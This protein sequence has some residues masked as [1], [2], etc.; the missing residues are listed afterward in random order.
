MPKKDEPARI[1]KSAKLSLKYLNKSKGSALD[2]FRDE[3]RRV[4]RQYIEFFWDIDKIPKNIPKSLYSLVTDSWLTSRALQCAAG[5]AGDIVRGTRTK[6]RQRAYRYGILLKEG[7][8]KAARKLKV[9]IDAAKVSKPDVKNVEPRLT[10]N[11]FSIDWDNPTSW[12]GI[13][14]LTSL[15]NKL[16]IVIPVKRH[17]H[18]N[19]LLDEAD[20]MCN[21]V[22]FSKSNVTLSF[23]M[24]VVPPTV[25]GTT[26]GLDIGM[27]NAFTTSDAQQST[28][29]IHGHTLNTIA[30]KLARK[31]KGS[32]AFARAQA[33]RTNYT[34]WAFNKIN[35]KGVS[36]LRVEN[37]KYLRR[38]KSTSRHLT[39]F[40]YPK[41]YAKLQ[42]LCN[43]YGCSMERV[44]PAYT[45]QRCSK[46]GRVRSSNRQG[47]LYKC[48]ACK[49]ECDSDYNAA[50][51]IAADLPP[52][53]KA[54]RLKRKNR[55]GFYCNAPMGTPI[56]SLTPNH[57]I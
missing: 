29:D 48:D 32:R 22:A 10:K 30:A 35:L 40:A 28:P 31:T 52:I 44:N 25:G 56:V 23:E 6:Q 14:T 19:K 50:L 46:C 3:Y 5:Q 39:H 45:S 55:K 57:K 24:P 33:H 49:T 21:V 36:T 18:F 51:N 8:L 47:R 17:R 15:G 1:I 7:K 53:S 34:G 26:I 42:D 2:V 20:K 41:I 43:S 11:C 27:I 54:M 4:V 12:D 13:I 38:G 9:T 37:I 16:K